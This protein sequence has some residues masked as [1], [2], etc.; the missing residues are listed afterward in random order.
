MKSVGSAEENHMTDSPSG[1]NKS[2]NMWEELNRP[3]DRGT[4]DPT[5]TDAR[6][7]DKDGFALSGIIGGAVAIAA[8]AF[9]GFIVMGG[10]DETSPADSSSAEVDELALVDDERP[11]YDLD[12]SVDDSDVQS[13]GDASDDTSTEDSEGSPAGDD[14]ALPTDAYSPAVPAGAE[15]NYSVLSRGKLYLRGEIPSPLIAVGAVDALEEILGEGNVISEYVVNPEAPFEMGRASDVFIEDTVLFEFGNAE[16]APDFYPLLGL[17]VVLLDIQDT[18]T[19]EVYGHT[20]S[21]GSDSANLVLSQARVDAV[22]AFWVSQGADPSR[23][24]A[25]GLGE[26]EPVADNSTAEGQQLNRRVEIV[27][28]GF[29]FS[30]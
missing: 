1:D 9:A 30:L 25:V 6:D 17:G 18:V 16:I 2:T 11:A 15:G 20:D 27:I 5:A 22:K 4:Q 24:T 28:S 23:I 3:K 10:G 7:D 19:I 29:V 14:S 8:V 12:G 13:D 26:G 21:A